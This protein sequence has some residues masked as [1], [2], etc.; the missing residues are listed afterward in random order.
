MGFFKNLLIE[1]VPNKNQSEIYEQESGSCEEIE[2]KIEL[3]DIKTDTLIEDS[4]IQNDLFDK[5]KSIFKIEELINSLPKEMVTETKRTSVLA[6]LGVFGLTVTDVTFDGENRINVLSSVLSKIIENSNNTISEKETKI[7]DYKKQI[8]LLENE[9]ADIKTEVSFSENTINS[10]ISRITGLI[11][12][13]E[14]GNV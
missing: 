7:E 5:T 9:V 2:V 8:A 11:K 10:E 14:G 12:F 1:E 13:I 6:A 3:E 4:Y